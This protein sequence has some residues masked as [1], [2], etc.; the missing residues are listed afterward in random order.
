MKVPH[1]PHKLFSLVIIGLLIQSCDEAPNSKSKTDIHGTPANSLPTSLSLG[2]GFDS[3]NGSFTHDNCTN[4]FEPDTETHTGYELLEINQ[5]TQTENLE[6]VTIHNENSIGTIDGSSGSISI[7]QT[8]KTEGKN[9]VADNLIYIKK[10]WQAPKDRS[11]IAVKSS[12]VNSGFTENC[13]D[14]FVNEVAYG[15]MLNLKLNL[16]GQTEISKNEATISVTAGNFLTQI[17][18]LLSNLSTE[19]NRSS[20]EERSNLLVTASIST[21]VAGMSCNLA[22]PVAIQGSDSTVAKPGIFTG[23]C[24]VKNMASCLGL[25]QNI[26]NCVDQFYT[27]VNDKDFQASSRPLFI[28]TS[29]YP[30]ADAMAPYWEAETNILQDYQNIIEN[31]NPRIV[32]NI[33]DEL[34]R[35]SILMHKM[36]EQSKYCRFKLD[37]EADQ[38]QSCEGL[39][40]EISILKNTDMFQKYYTTDTLKIRGMTSL[41]PQ[42]LDAK[43]SGREFEY[44]AFR[45]PPHERIV[46]SCKALKKGPYYIHFQPETYLGEP[47][48]TAKNLIRTCSD[49]AITFTAGAEPLNGYL[50]IRHR[51]WNWAKFVRQ[52]R[53]SLCEL[54]P[55]DMSLNCGNYNNGRFDHVRIQLERH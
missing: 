25:A 21:N 4:L 52:H 42:N 30:T 22:G 33:T 44:F 28:S 47:V 11:R 27:K 8:N 23:M 18:S 38:T 50:W 54:G 17:T 39:K 13:G 41:D 35:I 40:E 12:K 1:F 10:S 31:L 7:D 16:E 55:R 9:L 19:V 29:P 14:E 2:L 43:T 3:R 51:I 6:E 48:K 49:E 36:N 46:I 34:H 20:T 24:N 15:A 26:K 45:I 37:T 32:P 53:P 5:L